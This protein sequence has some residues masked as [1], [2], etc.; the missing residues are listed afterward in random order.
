MHNYTL[1]AAMWE[2]SGCF[3]SSQTLGGIGVF[4]SG[5]SCECLG[6][7]VALICVGEEE[8]YALNVLLAGPR[9]RLT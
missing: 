5:Y 3:T 9:I 4:G 7:L 8:V 1:Q 2:Y 6:I